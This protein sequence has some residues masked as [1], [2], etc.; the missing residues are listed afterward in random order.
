MG[1]LDEDGGTN[2]VGEWRDELLYMHREE[3]KERARGQY[4]VHSGARCAF[5]EHP[6]QWS[7]NELCRGSWVVSGAPLALQLSFG[8][9]GYGGHCSGRGG[10]DESH[11][12]RARA[13]DTVEVVV[14]SNG[15]ALED[16]F[17]GVG[18]FTNGVGGNHLG[19]RV[20]GRH[21]AHRHKT[22]VTTSRSA[23]LA[24]RWLPPFTAFDGSSDAIFPVFASTPARGRRG[25]GHLHVMSAG[26]PCFRTR[27]RTLAFGQGQQ[28]IRSCVVPGVGK[29]GH[30]GNVPITVR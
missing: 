24:R 4:G 18:V 8:A 13:R 9:V 28:T 23:V 14:K 11:V 25:A 21:V 27:G 17:V 22:E 12:S 10:L 1:A 7:G 3:P 20:Y 6:T 19:A 16:P 29:D 30:D 5:C 15:P 26:P 2:H